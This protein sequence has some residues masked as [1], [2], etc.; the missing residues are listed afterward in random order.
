MVVSTFWRI[1]FQLIYFTFNIEKQSRKIRITFNILATL[2]LT[3]PENMNS[4]PVFNEVRVA[5][6]LVFCVVY[7]FCIY[8]F[9]LLSFIFC[10]SFELR[11]WW[12]P[13]GVFKLF[14]SI[15]IS[16]I[17]INI[18]YFYAPVTKSWGY[19]YLP[20]SVR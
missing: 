12:P 18:L 7:M 17:Y 2:L 9:L 15:L 20:L 10:L 14:L 4:F 8:L 6:S 1:K 16:P 5:Q 11:F 3:L 19:I 13:F